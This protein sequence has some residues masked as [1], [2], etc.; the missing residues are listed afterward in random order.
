MQLHQELSNI[1]SWSNASRSLQ[2]KKPQ[3]YR[4]LMTYPGRSFNERAYLLLNNFSDVPCCPVTN[5]Q[6]DFINISSGYRPFARGVTDEE[7]LDYLREQKFPAITPDEINSIPDDHYKKVS[8]FIRNNQNLVGKILQSTAFLPNEST[9]PERVYCLKQ[10]IHYNQ[11]DKTFQ[12]YN[13]GYCN[14]KE[15]FDYSSWAELIGKSDQQSGKTIWYYIDRNKNRDTT[16]WLYDLPESDENNE[17]VVCPVLG[18]R[19]RHLKSNYIENVLQMTVQEFEDKYPKQLRIAPGRNRKVSEGVNR[20]DPETGK[21]KKEI[22]QEKSKEI[23]STRGEDGLTGYERKGQKTR[24]SH[25]E[26]VDELGRNGYSQLASKAIVT[27]NLTKAEKGLITPFEERTEFYRYKSVVMYLSNQLK[28]EIS[29][30]YVLGRPGTPDAYNVDHIY[31]IFQG[32]QNEVSPLVIGHRENLE[33]ISWE[34]NLSK[35]SNSNVSLEKLYKRT[36]YT[37]QQSKREF[38]IIMDIIRHHKKQDYPIT[39]G[40]VLEEFYGKTRL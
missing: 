12:S 24:Q 5:E 32:Y 33:V 1:T 39:G 19:M 11:P 9:I 10:G 6:K 2:K 13:R 27:G 3:V 35:W 38:D 40:Y 20:I 21:T 37:A 4:Q 29:E 17:F 16:K 15:K 31:S 30:G 28:N 22:S 25:M 34:E 7:V 23:L 26:N 8:S 18:L 14:K 36:Q